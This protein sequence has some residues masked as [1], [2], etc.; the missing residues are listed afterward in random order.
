MVHDIAPFFGC[1]GTT[2]P[3][4]VLTGHHSPVVS[5]ALNSSL[6][7]VASGA[8]C[9]FIVNLNIALCFIEY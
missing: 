5:V 4:A 2:E 8:L 3:I 1:V 9:K 6:G 7:I